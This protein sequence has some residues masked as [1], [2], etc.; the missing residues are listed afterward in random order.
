MILVPLLLMTF[1]VLDMGMGIFLQST[2]QRAVR[3]GVRYGITGQNTTGPCEDDSIRTIVQQNALGFLGTA[4][5]LSAIKVQF[6]DPATG[7]AAS[8]PGNIPGNILEV[9][10]QGWQFTPFG[11][12]Q[13]LGSK[14]DI[15][16]NSFDVMEP[17]PGTV[18]CITHTP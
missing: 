1:F 11:Q 17:Y 7:A 9:S 16:A 14:L 15:S 8:A 5:G 6:I 10:V 13:R 18:P 3:A 12:F 4:G 2:F